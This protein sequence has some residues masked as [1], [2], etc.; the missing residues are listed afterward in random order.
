MKRVSNKNKAKFIILYHPSNF[1][2]YDKFLP[3]DKKI[4]RDLPGILKNNIKENV[5]HFINPIKALSKSLNPTYPENG[6]VHY[7]K[8]GS[9]VVAKEIFDH[10]NKFN[11]LVK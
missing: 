3:N 1:E 2:V 11:M 9:K 6:E 4:I 10:L 7:N 5:I 8:N